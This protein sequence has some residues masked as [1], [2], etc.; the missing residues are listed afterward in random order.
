MMQGGWQQDMKVDRNIQTLIRG[1][2]AVH[3]Y[4]L[5]DKGL[6]VPEYPCELQKTC[7]AIEDRLCKLFNAVQNKE[8]ARVR[9]DA[10]DIIVA[11]SKI[12]EYTELL[13]KLQANPAT[14]K[15]GGTI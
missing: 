14:Q 15:N 11:A 6:R 5:S 1:L 8:Y 9:E 7:S 13:T 4:M 3:E 2:K 12:I 10:A